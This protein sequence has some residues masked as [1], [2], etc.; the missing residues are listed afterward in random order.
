MSQIQL[1]ADGYNGKSERVVLW[2]LAD[3]VYQLEFG[4]GI[5]KRPLNYYDISY[6]DAMFEFEAALV[7][8][9]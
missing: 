8:T 2:R 6:E 1:I 5:N 3:Y 7:E 4:T 9:H